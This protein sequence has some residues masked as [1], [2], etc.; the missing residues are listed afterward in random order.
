M[1]GVLRPDTLYGSCVVNAALGT[2]ASRT[3]TFASVVRTGV[4]VYELALTGGGVTIEEYAFSLTPIVASANAIGHNVQLVNDSLLRV[5][6]SNQSTAFDVDFSLDIGRRTT[7][8]VNTY[9]ASPLPPPPPGAAGVFG[10]GVST[11]GA[12]A[13]WDNI[14]GTLLADTQVVIGAGGDTLFVPTGGGLDSIGGDL[15]IGLA[16]ATVSIGLNGATSGCFIDA[17]QTLNFA[18][19]NALPSVSFSADPDTGMF[20]VAA[21]QL[22]FATAGVLRAS[23]DATG[24]HVAASVLTAPGSA[25]TPGH[26]FEVDP[27]TGMFRSAVNTLDFSAGG[28]SYMT[29]TTSLL[30]LAGNLNMSA[31]SPT[32]TGTLAGATLILRGNVGATSSSDDVQMV[33]QV[34]RTNGRM[35]SL[36]NNATRAFAV[37]YHGGIEIAQIAEAGN[38]SAMIGATA[39]AHTALTAGAEFTDVNLDCSATAT[40]TAGAI[41][42]LRTMRLQARTYSCGSAMTVTDAVTFEVSGAPTAAGSVTITNPY[43]FRVAAGNALFGGGMLFTNSISPAQ[44]TGNQNDYAPGSF[45]TTYMVLQDV[46][47]AT[48]NVTGLA[49]GVAGRRVCFINISTNAA[50]ILRFTNQDA[51]SS[52]ANRFILPNAGNYDVPRGGSI[53]FWYDGGASR[54]RVESRAN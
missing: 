50:S 46:D 43:A 24:F 51:A 30:T 2:F 11:L 40:F 53:V 41:A 54:W 19:T 18:G 10:P 4:G 49:G 3:P 1:T 37:R 32:I 5:R 39:A 34:T 42:T 35:L 20:R 13:V 33:T 23:I 16:A 27:D 17:D 36:F 12:I 45:A 47:A 31:A 52:A 15:R 6:T 38:F 9:V 44:L 48:R 26:S 14:V 7:Q 25:G 28:T 22:G 8:A 21:N 29:L